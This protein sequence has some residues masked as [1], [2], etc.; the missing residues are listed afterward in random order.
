MTY[1]LLDVLFLALKI[2]IGVVFVL[3]VLIAIAKRRGTSRERD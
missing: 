3:L 1:V 2:E